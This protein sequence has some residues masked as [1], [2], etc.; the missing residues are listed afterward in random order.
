MVLVF[1]EVA[2][3][4]EG[5]RTRK[6]FKVIMRK[7]TPGRNLTCDIGYGKTYVCR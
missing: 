5:A 6:N 7:I 3:E 1:A 2:V 4:A